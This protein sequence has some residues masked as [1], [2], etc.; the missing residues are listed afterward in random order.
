MVMGCRECLS[1]LIEIFYICKINTFVGY[2]EMELSKIQ[3][4][5]NRARNK[6]TQMKLN[7]KSI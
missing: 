3:P 7:G 5:W 4:K 6:D 1:I 2:D